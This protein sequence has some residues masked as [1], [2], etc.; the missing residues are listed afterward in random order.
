MP[1][2]RLVQPMLDR[3]SEQIGES[4][5]VSILDGTEIVYVARAAQRKVMSLA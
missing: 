2:P 4:A 1:L 3:L 5:S